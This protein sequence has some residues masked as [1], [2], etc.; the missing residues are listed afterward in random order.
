MARAEL[1]NP[2]PDDTG[3]T[4]SETDVETSR[5]MN[6]NSDVEHGASNASPA[7]GSVEGPDPATYRVDIE[8][9]SETDAGDVERGPA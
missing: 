8:S 5:G 1:P 9:G 2:S 4:E 7:I 3:R 6:V